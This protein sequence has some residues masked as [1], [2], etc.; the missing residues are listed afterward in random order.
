MSDSES[1]VEPTGSVEIPQQS[2]K[3]KKPRTPAQ[4]DATQKAL[5]ILKD[6]REALAKEKEARLA[7]ADT[8]E[9]ERMK[10]EEYEK[11]KSHKKKLPPVPSYITTGDLEVFKKDILSHMQRPVVKE[12]RPAPAPAPVPA[13]AKRQQQPLTGAAMLDQLIH[14]LR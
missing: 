3:I 10:A 8:A 6:R 5:Q 14:N 9:K 13:P 7:K 1:E 4:K 2:L 11:R 12:E